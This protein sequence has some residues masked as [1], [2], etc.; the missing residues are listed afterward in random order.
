[1]YNH[2]TINCRSDIRP[3]KLGCQPGDF[4]YGHFNL[5]LGFV[6][7]NILT[8]SPQKETALEGE[9]DKGEKEG[10]GGGCYII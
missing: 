3:H 4:A 9:R 1:M 8:L 2:T 7:V 5:P 6:W 10:G